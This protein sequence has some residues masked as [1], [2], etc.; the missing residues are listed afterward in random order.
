MAKV[1]VAIAWPYASG[2]RH[3]GHA[4]ATFIPADIFARYHRMKG[5]DVLVV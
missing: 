3:I 4:A 1:L 2:P 5:D